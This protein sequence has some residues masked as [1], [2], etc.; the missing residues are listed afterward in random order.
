MLK[1]Y[2][3]AALATIES[4]AYQEITGN[5]FLTPWDGFNRLLKWKGVSRCVNILIGGRPGS[6]KTLFALLM[7]LQWAKKPNVAVLF[8]SFEMTEEQI[9]AR[10]FSYYM[11][12]EIVDIENAVG[13]KELVNELND[14][15][16]ADINFWITSASANVRDIVQTCDTFKEQHPQFDTIVTVIDHTRLVSKT[17]RVPDVEH[18]NDFYREINDLKKRGFINVILSQVNR[19]SVTQNKENHYMPPS[20]EQFSGADAAEWYADLLMVIHNPA[21]AKHPVEAWWAEPNREAMYEMS[22][23]GR[24]WCEVYKNRLGDIGRFVLSQNFAVNNLS[25]DEEFVRL[26]KQI[27][28]NNRTQPAIIRASDFAK[29]EEDDYY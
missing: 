27:D 28:E 1:H 14:L 5:R 23:A 10:T 21:K 6:G 13:R 3:E 24:L 22:T 2:K 8:F 9:V 15:A 18:L 16:N 20:S 17:T 7:A 26:A 4:I 12:A 19:E 29:N 25:D 11:G